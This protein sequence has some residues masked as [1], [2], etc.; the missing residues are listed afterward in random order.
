[1][2]IKALTLQQPWAWAIATLHKTVE[3]RPIRTFHRGPLAIHA[4]KGTDWLDRGLAFLRELGLEPSPAE[5]HMGA[6][7]AIADVTDCLEY[8]A[9]DLFPSEAAKQLRANPFASGPQCYLLANIR[10]L[11]KPF[12]CKGQ[13]GFF[14]IDIPVE[15]L[16]PAP[17]PSS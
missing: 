14:P 13:Q 15:F 11:A 8:N 5:L 9:A 12:P 6:V 3:N 10:P 17:V 16:P 1:M 2:Q 7:V 4:G